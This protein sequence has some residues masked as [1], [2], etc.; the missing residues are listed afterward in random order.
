MLEH[1][2][3]RKK[4]LPGLGKDMPETYGKLA[5]IFQCQVF[6]LYEEVIGPRNS[7]YYIPYMMNDA[8]ECYLVLKD[9]R[10]TGE[11][12]QL[13]PEEFPL[14]AQIAQR[15][16]QTALI[17]KQGSENVFTIWF[18]EIEESFQC[19]QYHRIGHFWVEGQEHW[20][21]LVYMTGTIY[22][23]YEYMK[24]KA[25][26]DLEM[27]LMHLIEFPPFRFWSPVEESLEERYPSSPRGAACMKKLAKEAGDGMYAFLTGIYE[28]FPAGFLE[29]RLASMLCSPA[30]EPLYEMIY[31]KIRKASLA[32]PKRDYGEPLNTEIL[33]KRK[34]VNRRLKKAG[35]EGRYPFYRKDDLQIVATEEHP[36]TCMESRDFVFRI[37]FMVSKCRKAC[38]RNGGFFRSRDRKSW[39]L[40]DLDP[41]LSGGLERKS[42]G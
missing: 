7:S 21:Q 5:E 32:Y 2:E 26:S 8:L 28:R 37:Q 16:G 17:V 18:R 42:T 6:E 9:A 1:Y 31:E 19:Y 38:G 12:L 15:D 33:K 13:D 34:A 4:F 29:K 27:E 39:I 14:Q 41:V 25:C 22:D 35:F 24:E 40:E 36:F 20:R 11:Y 10:I 23:K 30:R 3:E